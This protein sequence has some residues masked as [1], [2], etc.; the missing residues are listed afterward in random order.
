MAR[1]TSN[2]KTSEMMRK[3]INP[4]TVTALGTLWK[5]R[6]EELTARAQEQG[7]SVCYVSDR[8]LQLD[9]LLK[10]LV[11]VFV[12]R[13]MTRL[14]PPQLMTS[15]SAVGQ[16]RPRTLLPQIGSM[17]KVLIRQMVSAMSAATW[18][19]MFGPRSMRV[20]V[21]SVPLALRRS[22]DCCRHGRG[23]CCRRRR[24][25][26]AA[27]A[28]GAAGDVI[29]HRNLRNIAPSLPAPCAQLGQ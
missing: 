25:Y 1:V 18:R 24:L 22:S 2:L 19:A 8:C 9:R 13:K 12:A 7:G 27:V 6:F 21:W 20:R 5:A 11:Q 23:R 28:D 17:A 4:E 16:Q 29:L 26:K 10:V 3:G 15:S 14:C